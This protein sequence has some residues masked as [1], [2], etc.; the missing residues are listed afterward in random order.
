MIR[1]P[2]FKELLSLKRDGETK[3]VEQ[4]QIERLLAEDPALAEEDKQFNFC[5]DALKDAAFSEVE[6]SPDFNGRVIR[7]VRIDK[8]RRSIAAL[9]PAIIGAVTAAVGLVAIIQI[10]ATPATTTNPELRNQKAE[11]DRVEYP[12]IPD[13]TE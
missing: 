11:L 1:R 9:T 8:K 13:F 5:F 6:P 10:I 4:K 2:N 7:R 3:L 12:I